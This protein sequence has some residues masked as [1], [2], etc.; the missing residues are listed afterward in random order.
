MGSR[1]LGMPLG[2][3]RFGNPPG[4]VVAICYKW[5]LQFNPRSNSGR[6]L[7]GWCSDPCP[8]FWIYLET[9]SCQSVP[10]M[11]LTDTSLRRV[12]GHEFREL[13]P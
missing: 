6:F 1:N 5:N 8:S 2:T 7:Y 4:R 9:E 13:L 10:Q 11:V 12:L 3:F